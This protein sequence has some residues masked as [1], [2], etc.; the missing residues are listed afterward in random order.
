MPPRKPIVAITDSVR[1][2]AVASGGSSPVISIRITFGRCRIRQ[3]A[4]IAPACA[5]VPMPNA[6]APSAPSVHVWLSPQQTVIPGV[7]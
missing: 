6:N 2:F 3:P 5:V 7:T 1:S 4:S